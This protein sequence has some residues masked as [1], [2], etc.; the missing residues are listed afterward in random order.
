MVKTKY[1]NQ[2]PM[3]LTHTQTGQRGPPETTGGACEIGR[4]PFLGLRMLLVLLV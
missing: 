3:W 4:K 2:I 1:Q